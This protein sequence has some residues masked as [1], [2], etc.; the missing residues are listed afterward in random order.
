MTRTGV[1]LVILLGFAVSVGAQGSLTIESTDGLVSIQADRV[2]LG[3]LLQEL[4]AAAGTASFVPPG[5][6][7][8]PVSVWFF[9]LPVRQAVKKAFEG[10][11]LDYAV[12]EG[13][14]IVVLNPSA[15]AETTLANALGAPPAGF[16]R[17]SRNE[18]AQGQGRAALAG[19]AGDLLQQFLQGNGTGGTDIRELIRGFQEGGGPGV[20][21]AQILEQLR[22]RTGR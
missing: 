7:N 22:G 2:G 6:Y 14:R 13:S 19:R 17:P 12:I 3:I 18:D 15:G 11:S 20:D 1:L 8:L 9:D 10:L 4:D 5:L 21:P 16:Q